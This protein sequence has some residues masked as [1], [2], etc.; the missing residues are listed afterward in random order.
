MVTSVPHYN[1]IV[2]HTSVAQ[3]SLLQMKW[4][5]CC[6]GPV[7]TY[8][9][10]RFIDVLSKFDLTS[11][12]LAYLFG[13]LYKSLYC[14]ACC[15]FKGCDKAMKV[16]TKTYVQKRINL[17]WSLK[18]KY[19]NRTVTMVH[20]NCLGFELGIFIPTKP[21]ATEPLQSADKVLKILCILLVI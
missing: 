21:F 17:K 7:P 2:M 4:F 6:E 18:I 13:T 20:K 10:A 5:L 19:S 14:I 8:Q 16:L 3:Y 1:A 9:L 12:F 11:L 15:Y